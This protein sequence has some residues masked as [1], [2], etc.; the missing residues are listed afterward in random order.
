MLRQSS[1]IV[2]DEATAQIDKHTDDRI[3][4]VIRSYFRNNTVLTIAHRITTIMD[5][6]TIL[7]L[8]AGRIVETGDPQELLSA[9]GLFAQL[10]G[11][12]V[13]EPSQPE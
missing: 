3:Q 6:D 8:D 5:Y 1:I 10:S 4:A 12:S 11:N 13:A 2:F 9:N 7:V